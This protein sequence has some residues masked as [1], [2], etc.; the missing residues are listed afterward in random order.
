MSANSVSLWQMAQN[1]GLAADA[2]DAVRGQEN[3]VSWSEKYRVGVTD[4]GLCF[5][6]TGIQGLAPLLNKREMCTFS[7]QTAENNNKNATVQDDL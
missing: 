5:V 7:N 4:Q 3:Y 1:R 6:A 2:E